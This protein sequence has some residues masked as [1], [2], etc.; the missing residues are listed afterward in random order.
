[1]KLTKIFMGAGLAAVMLASCTNNSTA[2]TNEADAARQAQADS[3]AVDFGRLIGDQY[4]AV[5]ERDTNYQRPDAQKEFILGFKQGMTMVTDQQ[6]YNDGIMQGI[7]LAMTLKEFN[8]RYKVNVSPQTVVNSLTK[9]IEGGKLEDKTKTE[10]QVEYHR[11]MISLENAIKQE[12]VI[13]APEPKQESA[14]ETTDSVAAEPEL[15]AAKSGKP[16]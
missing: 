1:M 14:P 5:V 2:P 12:R 6:T 11:L 3:L 8:K 16:E 9:A 10:L 4:F 13:P 7:Q 15:D